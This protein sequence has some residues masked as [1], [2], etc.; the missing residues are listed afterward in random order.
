[1]LLIPSLNPDGSQMVVEWYRDTVGKPW[2]GA[3][4]PFLYHHYAGHDNNRDWYAFTQR[5]TQLTIEHAH[6]AWH[7]QIVHDI[8]QMGSRGARFFLPPYLDPIEPNVDP[9]LVAGVNQL[10]MFMAWEMTREGKRGVVVNSIYDAWTPGRAYPHYHAGVRILSETASANMASPVNLPFDTLQS[11]INFNARESGWNFAAPWLGG[12]WRLRDIVDYQ[13]SGA[14]ALLRHASMHRAEWLRSFLAVGE[15]AMNGWYGWP[16]AWVIPDAG[17]EL[18]G[19][20][21]SERT[22]VNELLRILTMGGV[23]VLRAT[24]PF[25]AGGQHIAADSYVIFMQQPYAAFA[26]TLLERQKYPDLRM[27]PGGPPRRPYDVTAHTLPLLFNVRAIPVRPFVDTAG[28]GLS[29][30]ITTP[31]VSRVANGLTRGTPGATPRIAMYQSYAPSMDEGWTRWILDA[32]EI[33]FTTVRDADV[34]GGSLRARFDAIILPSQSPGELENG[35]RERC[36]RID[37]FRA[38]GWHTHRARAVEPLRHRQ[39]R[40]AGP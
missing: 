7:P 4:P 36:A 27:Y 40:A 20:A 18:R 21:V 2:E 23:D 24:R 37:R 1:V 14:F 35:R 34:Q 6:N 5:E 30:P 3:Q 31:S 32:Y 12:A 10:G 26:Q 22:R 25:D 38:F 13:E 29:R 11:G 33:P 17:P 16:S 8:H 15:R 39:A 9:L 19:T 28:L